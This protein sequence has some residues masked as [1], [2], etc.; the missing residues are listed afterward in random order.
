MP[1]NFHAGGGKLALLPHLP[2]SLRALRTPRMLNFYLGPSLHLKPNLFLRAR[3]L[4]HLQFLQRGMRAGANA[5]NLQTFCLSNLPPGI[6]A[7]HMQRSSAPA[8]WQLAPA[9]NQVLY[10]QSADVCSPFSDGEASMPL[11]PPMLTFTC[12]PASRQHAT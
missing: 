10:H 8:F 3:M 11:F 1:L 4:A 6:L 7:P 9:C 12:M 5:C 2:L